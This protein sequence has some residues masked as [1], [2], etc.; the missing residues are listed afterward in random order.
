MAS[1]PQFLVNPK[2]VVIDPGHG[3][4][5]RV[6]GSD[7]NHATS[8]SGVQEKD[9]TLDL[10]QQ[11]ETLLTRFGGTRLNVI[12]TRNND[13]NLGLAARAN[14]ARDNQA[15]V[16]VSIHFNGFNGVTRGVE[17]FVRPVASN[18]NLTDDTALAQ[19]VLDATFRAIQNRDAHTSN[20]GVKQM[21]LGVLDDTALGNTR[22]NHPCRAC[23]IEVEFIDVPAVDTLLNTGPGAAQVKSEIA[24]AISNGILADL[25]AHP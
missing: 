11:V 15:D 18:V 13:T 19:R 16:F 23:L 10:A 25:A 2:T 5:G 9:M 12:L 8:P 17:V 20:R 4:T 3:G 22:A 7:G 6:G 24:A 1:M 21:A 14:V